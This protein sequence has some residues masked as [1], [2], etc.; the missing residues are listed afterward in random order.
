MIGVRERLRT[1][2][3][4]ANWT[5]ELYARKGEGLK[6]RMVQLKQQNLALHAEVGNMKRAFFRELVYWKVINLELQH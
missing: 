5:H 1:V 2:E 6:K 3:K 4:V